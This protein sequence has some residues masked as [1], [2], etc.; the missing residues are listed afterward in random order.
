[1]TE[2]NIDDEN[3][4]LADMVEGDDL[5]KEHEVHVLEGLRVLGFAAGS[6]LAV[7][8]IVVREV[9]YETAG[10]GG[11]I[12]KMRAPVVEQDL[13]EDIGGVIG[14]HLYAA[15]LHDAVDAG[16]VHLRVEAEEGVAAPGLVDAGGFQQEAVLIHIFEDP[17]CLDGRCEIGEDLTA[18]RKYIIVPALSDFPDLIQFG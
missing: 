10:E 13:A 5:V 6:G 7:S 1:M 14:L 9:S 8:E 3:D 12:V 2:V 15:G 11:Q 17:H 18:Q 16:D 4:L